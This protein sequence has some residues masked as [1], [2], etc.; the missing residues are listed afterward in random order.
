[1]HTYIHTVHVRT[2]QFKILL[3]LNMYVCIGVDRASPADRS[4]L[5]PSVAVRG[6][7]PV[8]HVRVPDLEEHRA[9]KY[10]H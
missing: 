5:L 10:L 4:A 1:M 7:I 6:P 9:Q 3:F 2:R 8:H